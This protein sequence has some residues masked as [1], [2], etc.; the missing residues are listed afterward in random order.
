MISKKEFVKIMRLIQNFHSEQDTISAFIKKITHDFIVVDIG[1]CLI[2]TIINLL[3]MNMGIQDTEL[4]DWWLYEDVNK[5]IWFDDGT[6]VEVET[7]EQLYDYI[8]R[9]ES[10]N[11]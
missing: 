3:N 8:I 4:L 1:D 5:M 2:D 10:D 9:Y 6:Q 11:Q 7:P